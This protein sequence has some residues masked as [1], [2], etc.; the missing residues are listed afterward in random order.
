MFTVF[1]AIATLLLIGAVC[2]SVG[3][4]DVA[5]AAEGEP[6]PAT[7][8]VI[9]L[10]DIN[11]LYWGIDITVGGGEPTNSNLRD[12][13]VYTYMY[14]NSAG[15]YERY[16]SVVKLA[17]HPD[18]D[19]VATDWQLINAPDVKLSIVRARS[20][21][22]NVEYKLVLKGKAVETMQVKVDYEQ[23]DG[24]NRSAIKIGSYK[25]Q[26]VLTAPDDKTF[27]L[28]E[29]AREENNDGRGMT[30]KISSDGKSAT[31][32]KVWYV[33]K[34]DNALLNS[35]ESIKAGKEIEFTIPS[36]K[37]G[38]YKEIKYPWLFHGDGWLKGSELDANYDVKFDGKSILSPTT[39]GESWDP[40]DSNQTNDIV[41]F[42]LRKDGVSLTGSGA[43]D[44]DRSVVRSQWSLYFNKYMPAGNY[45]LIFYVKTIQL[46]SH[47]HWWDGTSH[48]VQADD[49]NATEEYQGFTRTFNFSV[50]P[51]DLKITNSATL[52][53]SKST[54][55]KVDIDDIGSAKGYDAVFPFIGDKVNYNMEDL[56]TLDDILAEKEGSSYWRD[57]ASDYFEKEPH[58]E[59]NLHR[60]SSADYY[61]SDN[62]SIWGDYINAPDNY[63][64]YYMAKMKNYAS[65]PAMD[66][67]YVY[68][69]HVTVYQIISNPTLQSDTLTYTGGLQS[70]TPVSVDPGTGTTQAV[71]DTALYDWSGHTATEP[72][73]YTVTFTFNV[74]DIYVWQLYDDGTTR[75]P[76]DPD[77]NRFD[78]VCHVKWKIDPMPIDA[79]VIASK[80]YSGEPQSAGVIIKNNVL[81]NP[82]EPIYS[83]S[84]P[85]DHQNGM[86]TDAETYHI[87]LTLNNNQN[88]QYKRYVWRGDVDPDNDGVITVPFVINPE[89]NEWH[90]T[91]RIR[92]WA[93][94]GFDRDVNLIECVPM[95]GTV[96]YTLSTDEE[97]N[98][99][100]N[101]ALK[102]FKADNNDST[103]FPEEVY[104]ALRILNVG[105][106]YLHARV[107]DSESRNFTGIK[108][109]PY[110][111][112]VTKARNTW[113][114]SP[115]IIR[116]QYGSF[117]PA[118]NIISA[119]PEF[120]VNVKFAVVVQKSA[121]GNTTLDTCVFG[122]EELNLNIDGK[123][124]GAT[125][126]ALEKLD[127]GKTYYLRA[128]VEGSNDYTELVQY[129]EFHIQ[130]ARN[131]WEIVPNIGRWVSGEIP[132]PP[133]GKAKY[134]KEENGCA[135]VIYK[136][137]GS[138]EIIYDN[139]NGIN[140]LSSASP[141]RYRMEA[142][143][144]ETTNYTAITGTV[145]FK[146]FATDRNFWNIVPNI[147]SW[148][149]GTAHNTPVGLSAFGEIEYSYY[150]RSEFDAN[151]LNAK[152]LDGI[153]S[154][155]GDYVMVA[156][157]V[158]DVH[159]DMIASVKFSIYKDT[160][161]KPVTYLGIIGA[162]AGIIVLTV[163]IFIIV[164]AVQRKK[165]K[166]ALET[167]FNPAPVHDDDED[168]DMDDVNDGDDYG[169][170][171]E[172]ISEA[173]LF[174]KHMDDG[175]NVVDV[176]DIQ[177]SAEPAI[178]P[179]FID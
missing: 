129:H 81:A 96:H 88:S 44:A 133:V 15:E 175:Q 54:S 98:H 68:N 99:T 95:R 103:K 111:F 112:E 58:L 154:V 163:L 118:V 122:L 3:A 52:G 77:S 158:S 151:G 170:E 37:F 106:Y 1:V 57:H 127:A 16:F 75:K 79:P 72:G 159:E 148:T 76:E 139:I 22:V 123:A 92:Q 83:V 162:L 39:P 93:W 82:A 49:V 28:S 34:F 152:K 56:I 140:N 105:T 176:D 169:V 4:K 5:V 100:V 134:Q 132:N 66:N 21:D 149:E 36:W 160:T 27:T 80:T 126:S 130:Q 35:D 145:E 138:N 171:N 26:A 150:L 173:E 86:F 40:A 131:Y 48:T 45:Q 67:R 7:S 166:K 89:V 114:S 121:T 53:N 30:I 17:S 101:D 161:V 47:K 24:Y 179:T 102:N 65:F 78:P 9:N 167:G 64:V 2:L 6:A 85:S 104:E 13:R 12:G 41:K 60:M 156:K 165:F 18:P 94:N 43:V 137:D 125:V 144:E 69:Y 19:T 8:D 135:F 110:R 147:Q 55:V 178:E 14:R 109:D 164:M 91:P 124:Q 25:A 153:P 97:G 38:E 31:I 141:G 177:E 23:P 59:Y 116:W 90:V 10:S 174:A 172:E 32:T 157:A 74:K 113:E 63:T 62:K 119:K 155:A 107:L 61:L 70:V 42:E 71:G 20:S 33:A 46:T 168:A 84:Y 146:I 73:E 142:M 136:D 50:L 143:V 51:G 29:S 115:N 108:A 117:D 11:N 128:I 87:T 120:G